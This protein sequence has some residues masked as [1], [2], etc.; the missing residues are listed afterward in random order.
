V[1]AWWNVVNWAE[2]NALY[3]AVRAMYTRSKGP[4]VHDARATQPDPLLRPRRRRATAGRAADD[5]R[6]ISVPAWIEPTAG[7]SLASY[8]GGSAAHLAPTEPVFIGGVSFGGMVAQEVARTCQP[9]ASCC[10][11]R[12]GRGAACRHRTAGWPKPDVLCRSGRSSRQA[13][14]DAAQAAD[15]PR[16]GQHLAW[17]DAMLAD[18]D[19]AFLQWAGGALWT[20]RASGPLTVPYVQIQGARDLICR[21]IFG[22]HA[23]Y[24]AGRP[25]RE[26]HA[27]TD[28]ECDREQ[29]PRRPRV[30][31]GPLSR[32]AERVM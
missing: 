20:G 4:D 16:D 26:H 7:E 14:G 27:R 21:P 13:P 25:P 22:A 8:G 6:D 29:L 15:G 32:Y 28:G 10:W 5:R 1:K 12:A 3:A 30:A 11:R 19:P 17:F 24:P 9:A 23:H 2:V 18:T 31:S